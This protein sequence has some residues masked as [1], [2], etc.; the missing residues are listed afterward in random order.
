[1]N[2]EDKVFDK[3]Q[4]ENTVTKV[5]K[6][7]QV[8]IGMPVYMGEP[9]I[10]EALNSL[11]SQNYTDFELIISDNA[12]TDSTGA[13]CLEYVERDA[14][15]RYIKQTENFGPLLNFKFVLN[16]AKGKY[17]MWAAADD[18]WL[19]KF[20]ELCVKSL[21][22]DKNANFAM[23]R[24]KVISRFSSIL[25]IKFKKNLISFIENK[26][27][28]KRVLAY[29]KLK[30]NTHKDNLIYSLWRK[31]F[32]QR[33]I[34]EICNISNMNSNA[35]HFLVHAEQYAL[36]KS[37]GKFIPF[38]LFLKTYSK[39]PPG[40]FLIRI[41]QTIKKFFFKKK[42]N[43]TY[44]KFLKFSKLTLQ[45][46]GAKKKFILKIISITKKTLN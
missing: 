34:V 7:P 42:I 25:K 4:T 13:I 12:S 2:I 33:V 6:V 9:F 1:M 38:V 18:I 29:S 43:T 15:I 41:Y 30:F 20:L 14:R 19:P 22:N 21:D 24:Y 39:I 31:R 11:L 5:K 17:F 35:S 3:S 32:L 44:Q 23:T 27:K 40:H 45:L 37:H 46:A 26:D 36:Y 16:Q 8:S 10:R 28:E